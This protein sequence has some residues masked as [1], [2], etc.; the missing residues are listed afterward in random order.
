MKTRS[1]FTVCVLTLGFV[2]VPAV[3]NL[4][5]EGFEDPGWIAGADSGNW[6]GS[7]TRAV[8]G[9]NGITS[10]TGVAHALVGT[11]SGSY[12]RLGGY[13]SAFGQG[14][15]TSLDVYLDPTWA[16]G[17]GFEWSAAANKQDGNHLR[18]FIWHVGVV[19]GKGLLVNTSNNTDFSVNAWKLEN[20]NGGAYVTVGGAGWYTLENVFYDN[21]GILAVDYNLKDSGGTI[22]GSWTR[23]DVGDLIASVVGGNRYGWITYNNVN[24]LAIDN[25][26]LSS[27]AIPAPGAAVLVL[28]GMPVVGWLK[29]RLA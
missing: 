21:G 14:F 28:I 15:V 10:A 25:T 20:E 16:A 12:T 18:D 19:S 9:T 29:R 17:Q 1:I 7:V 5:F 11:G 2:V 4:H 26:S 8:S 13:N 24:G 6:Q 27:I 22:V 23:S 3:A